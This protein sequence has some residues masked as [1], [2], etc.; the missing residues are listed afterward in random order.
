MAK[1]V[2]VLDALTRTHLTL[3]RLF[4]IPVGLNASW[5]PVFFLV[6]WS[7][8]TGFLPVAAPAAETGALWAGALVGTV[9][10]FASILA[11]E[12]GHALAARHAG[13]GVTSVT[14]FVLGGVSRIAEEP[15]S[16]WEELRIAAAGPA[17]S[18]AAAVFF[19]AMAP[20]LSASPVASSVAIYLLLVNAALALFNLLPALPLDGGRVLRAVLWGLLGDSS[21]ATRWAAWSGRAC[22]LL[23]I[24]IGGVALALGAFV[25]AG[26]M[27]L[28]GIFIERSAKGSVETVPFAE[29][30]LPLLLEESMEEARFRKHEAKL[31]AWRARLDVLPR[32][33]ELSSAEGD[34]P[35]VRQYQDE[36]MRMYEILDGVE[37]GLRALMTDEEIDTELARLSD[38]YSEWRPVAMEDE[39]VPEAGEEASLA[40]RPERF[41]PDP[42]EVLRREPGSSIEV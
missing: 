41:A 11:H 31:I 40:G 1:P 42:E 8:G 16:A 4:D 3:G 29:S 10:F 27:L 9:L 18:L 36:R 21:R 28:L 24:A 22:G 23:F 35:D 30:A 20:L 33:G 5:F 38:L 37:H 39:S 17:V 7:L 15:R 25:P 34:G 26:W 32:P 19:L 6:A 12:F 13:I 2:T 14:L